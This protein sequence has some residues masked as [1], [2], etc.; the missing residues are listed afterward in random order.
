MGWNIFGHTPYTG[1]YTENMCA[2]HAGKVFPSSFFPLHAKT[3]VSLPSLDLFLRAARGCG[4]VIAAVLI[5]IHMFRT[6][7]T[8]TY[9]VIF[10]LLFPHSLCLGQEVVLFR[11]E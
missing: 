1:P 8:T 10:K 11:K 5:C 3:E 7:F 2:K 9:K 6:S 4:G